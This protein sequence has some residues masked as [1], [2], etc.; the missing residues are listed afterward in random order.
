MNQ[1]KRKEQ[2]EFSEMMAGGSM[3]VMITI[4]IL[5]WLWKLVA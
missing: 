3:I 5:S 2:I 1:G 4:I